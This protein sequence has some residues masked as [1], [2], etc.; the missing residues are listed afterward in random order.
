M[1]SL[2]RRE[3]EVLIPGLIVNF[4]GLDGKLQLNSND[5]WLVSQKYLVNIN[6]VHAVLYIP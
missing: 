5:I 1:V 2:E 3:S 4:G 6:T